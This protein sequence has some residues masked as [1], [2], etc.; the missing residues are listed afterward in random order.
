[1]QRLS[2]HIQVILKAN[3]CGNIEKMAKKADELLKPC[4]IE[5]RAFGRELLAT[6]LAIR[7]L[8]IR[9]LTILTHHKPIVQAAQ[10]GTGTHNPTHVKSDNW[11]TSHPSLTKFDTSEVK[12][13]PSQV[14][15]PTRQLKLPPE[16]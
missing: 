13:M 15:Y 2:V 1:M 14:H 6:S 10:R 7:W 12:E 9:R 16:A 3:T 4:E 5:Y 8:E 11:T